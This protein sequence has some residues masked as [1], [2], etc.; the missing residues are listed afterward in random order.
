MRGLKAIVRSE[1][2]I[3]VFVAAGGHEKGVLPLLDAVINLMPSPKEI[4]EVVAQGKDGEEKLTAADSGPLAI[5]V[6]KTTADPF[7][8]KLTYFRVYS[9]S[10]QGD[11]RIWNQTKGAEERM[12]GLSIMRG[13]ETMPIKV[14]HSG[15]IGIVAKLSVTSTGDTLCDKSHPLTLPVPEIPECAFPRGD[16]TQDP[17]RRGQDQPTLTRLCEEDMTLSWYQEQAT[18]QT[19]LQGMGD[20]HIDVAIRRAEGKLQVGLTDCRAEGSVSGRH[21]QESRR[22]VPPQEAIRRFRP[23]WRSLAEDRAVPG[24]GL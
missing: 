12:A 20:Q 3:P 15:D 9:G 16:Q 5:Y 23:V 4:N 11:T 10:L 17:G 1:V 19:I 13:K 21:H 18:G 8:G 24:R 6:W 7:V 2:Y 22:H 14:V